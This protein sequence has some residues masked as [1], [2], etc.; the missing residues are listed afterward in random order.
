MA[1][2]EMEDFA[3]KVLAGRATFEENFRAGENCL[4]HHGWKYD[5]DRD[6]WTMVGV[7]WYGATTE[8]LA[9]YVHLFG[10]PYGIPC[11]DITIDFVGMLPGVTRSTSRWGFDPATYPKVWATFVMATLH[12]IYTCWECL[13][14]WSMATEHPLGFRN[15]PQDL[16]R[17]KWLNLG[18]ELHADFKVEGTEIIT[19][20]IVIVDQLLNRQITLLY[21]GKEVTSPSKLVYKHE[22]R[23]TLGTKTR[24]RPRFQE[25][26]RIDYPGI[27]KFMFL[28]TS[29]IGA[30][31]KLL[32]EV[33]EEGTWDHET[34]EGVGN[35]VKQRKGED[36]PLVEFWRTADEFETAYRKSLRIRQGC[37]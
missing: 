34:V 21:Q 10:H 28:V 18:D 13:S 8:K 9:K 20:S 3:A 35:Y 15:T 22:Y 1:V 27:D 33:R 32:A 14:S 19:K 5:E 23:N 12:D 25:S 17:N 2:T 30:R 37:E 7:G 31:E 6:I 11:R 24:L 26:W 4:R 16:R 36:V 29:Y